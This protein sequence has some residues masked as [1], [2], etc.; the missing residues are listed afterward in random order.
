M[1]INKKTTLFGLL[2]LLFPLAALSAGTTPRSAYLEYH[3]ALKSGL[4]VDAIWPYSTKAAK[5]EFE[6]TFPEEFRGRAFY[7]MKAAAPHEVRIT[8]ETIDGDKAT[9]ILVPTESH[10]R[11]TGTATLKR[12]DGLWKV[13]RVIWQGE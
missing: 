2:L 12:E 7:L 13:E 5:E 1:K 9:L 8:Q 6:R 3:V 10:R 11:V 4:S